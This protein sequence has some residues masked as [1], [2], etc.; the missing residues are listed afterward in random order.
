VRNGRSVEELVALLVCL[1]SS[2]ASAS[3]AVTLA[4]ASLLDGRETGLVAAERGPACIVSPAAETETTPESP[5]QASADSN[6]DWNGFYAGGRM[7]LATG[8][9]HWSLTGG[10]THAPLP[11]GSLRLSNSIHFSD[12]TGS[13][14]GGL[15]AGYNKV[16]PSRLLLGLETDAMFP[17][18][19]SGT[20]TFSSPLVGR[21]SYRDTVLASGSVRGRL[22]YVLNPWLLY[23]T[24]GFAWSYDQ[25]TRSRFASPS[26]AETA[27]LWRPGWSVGAGIGVPIGG[28]WSAALE[29]QYSNLGSGDVTFPAPAQTFTSDLTL[30]T[31]QLSLNYHVGHDAGLADLSEGPAPLDL[32][33]LALHGQ[34][35]FVGQYAFPFHAPYRGRNSLHPN[36]GRETWDVTL[37]AGARLWKGAEFWINPEIDQGF[38]LSNT[39]G[40]A[41]FPSGEDYKVGARVPYVRVPRFFLRQVINLGGD[42]QDVAAGINQ[43]PATTRANHLVLTVGKL[44]VTDIFDANRYAHDPRSDFMNWALVDTGSFD[45]AADAWG[46]TYGAV[47]EWFYGP[48]TLRGGGFDLSIVPNS[49]KLDPSFGQFQLVGEIERRFTVW[50]APGK[51]ALTPWLSRGRM[52]TYTAATRL[53][54]TTGQPADIAAV[55]RYRSRS[56]L[57]ANLEQQVT[58]DLGLF[59]RTGFASPNVEPY[60]FSDIDRTVAG[61]GQL[62]GGSWQRPDD[63]VGIAG[64]LNGISGRHEAFLNAG[65]LG[66]LV[67]DGRLPHPDLEQILETYYC[68]A[69]RAWRVTLDYQFVNNP[70]YNHDR[71]PVSVL[72]LRLH[73]QF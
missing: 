31:V 49:T 39:L 40:L 23:G 55:R 63:T 67:G 54:E 50:G 26:T 58:S 48:W 9:S 44:A 15:Q 60:E 7:S 16:L 36:Q 12:G 27:T 30:H 38:G 8:S 64:V 3:D 59:L 10:R 11:S 51:V 34:T 33:W 52:G 20:H 18:T 24:G 53:A 29:Y 47:A 4:A 13:Y 21:G 17:S 35:T 2:V 66:I 70:A 57:A 42:T 61:G 43:F 45:Y 72:G 32:D 56:G 37:Y 62:T 22:G 25:L 69:V 14:F 41:G 5:R 73:A 28:Q 19:I 68:L 71:G 46:Y 6:F 1:L 65:G